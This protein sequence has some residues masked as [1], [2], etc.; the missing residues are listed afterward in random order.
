MTVKRA[1]LNR[2]VLW[3]SDQPE[4]V[5]SMILSEPSPAVASCYAE[6]LATL[7]QKARE[8]ADR[9]EQEITLRLGGRSTP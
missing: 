3:F 6:F 5:R 2:L 8:A 7:A 4:E 1:A 9:G